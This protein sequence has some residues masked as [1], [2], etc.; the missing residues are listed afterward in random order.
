M[1]ES[2]EYTVNPG[3]ICERNCG[4]PAIGSPQGFPAC[5]DCLLACL[6]EDVFDEEE[7]VA[8]R[9]LL[10]PLWRTAWDRLLEDR[11]P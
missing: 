3:G 2:C 1:T 11:S 4:K 9:A 8:V 5:A 7:N 6:D 10:S